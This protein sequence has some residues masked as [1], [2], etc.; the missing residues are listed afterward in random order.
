MKLYSYRTY[1][2]IMYLRS[3][4][5]MASNPLILAAVMQEHAT[6]KSYGFITKQ[7]VLANVK[8]N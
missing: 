4:F 6:V 2:D 8:Q 7:S 3:L 5:C 1:N